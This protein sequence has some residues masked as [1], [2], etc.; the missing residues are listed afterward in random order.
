MLDT[1]TV[2][3]LGFKT[4][5]HK[6]SNFKLEEDEKGLS[7]KIKTITPEGQVTLEFNKVMQEL[8]ELDALQ[9][10]YPAFDFFINSRGGAY[11]EYLLEVEARGQRR[12]RALDMNQYHE[13]SVP[14]TTGEP[15]SLNLISGWKPIRFKN[16]ELEFQL[17]F[18]ERYSIS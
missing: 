2:T 17:Y 11:D 5:T 1:F 12:G 14:D 6:D 7:V 18:D 13:T 10:P 9:N 8:E 15:E 4:L 16:K 3:V